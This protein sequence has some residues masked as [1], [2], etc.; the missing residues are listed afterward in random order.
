MQLLTQ[1]IKEAHAEYDKLTTLHDAGHSMFAPGS[2]NSDETVSAAHDYY[3]NLKQI[4][5][6][7]DIITGGERAKEAEER[8]KKITGSAGCVLSRDRRS[9]FEDRTGC[10]SHP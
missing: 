5:Q 10:R 7:Q 4:K 3:E 1:S 9:R 2:G 8:Q 6:V